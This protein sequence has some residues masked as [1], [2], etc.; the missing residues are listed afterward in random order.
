[1]MRKRRRKGEEKKTVTITGKRANIKSLEI[2]GNMKIDKR[3]F[4]RERE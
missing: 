4:A 2:V 3:I 1:M